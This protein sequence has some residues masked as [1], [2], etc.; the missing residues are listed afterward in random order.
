[1]SLRGHVI[2]GGSWGVV[3]KLAS[4]VLTLLLYAA[5]ARQLPVAEMG[6]FV[7]FASVCAVIASVGSLGASQ[8][9]VRFIAAAVARENP[10]RAIAA[11]RESVAVLLWGALISVGV[12]RLLSGQWFEWRAFPGSGFSACVALLTAWVVALIVQRFAGEVCRGFKYIGFANF[13]SGAVH[14]G[15]FALVLVLSTLALIVVA[16][17]VVTTSTAILVII[18]CHLAAAAIAVLFVVRRTGIL[19]HQPD[20]VRVGVLAAALPLTVSNIAQTA[21][22]NGDVWILGATT[23]NSDLAVYGASA[24]LVALMVTPLILANSVLPPFIAA[25]FEGG[26]K[27]RLEGLLRVSATLSALPAVASLAVFLAFGSDILGIVYGDDYRSGA[28]ILVVLAVGYLFNALAGSSGITLVM[29][30]GERLLMV[31]S[32]IAALI[33]LVVAWWFGR[34]WGA[35]GVAGA[36]ALVLAVQNLAFV[37]AVRRKVGVWTLMTFSWRRFLDSWEV[38]R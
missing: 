37:V 19:A 34:T 14:G 35:L 2:R 36:V 20:T 10:G 30:G 22:A 33:L 27:A 13:I 32:S 31:I 8:S 15:P 23:S 12:M 38:V 16:G 24:K 17:G 1:M 9:V 21:L 4:A 28:S 29:T 7:L 18:V 25:L 11:I 3:W 6:R 26:E 5:L